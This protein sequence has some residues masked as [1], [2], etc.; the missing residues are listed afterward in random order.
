MVT[1]SLFSY[2][3]SNECTEEYNRPTKLDSIIHLIAS[4]WQ[5]L[6][7]V[8]KWSGVKHSV[9]YAC[10]ACDTDSEK[11]AVSFLLR[12]LNVGDPLGSRNAAISILRFLDSSLNNYL[13]TL[14]SPIASTSLMRISLSRLYSMTTRKTLLVI[15]VARVTKTS[16]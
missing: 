2:L 9:E 6:T 15:A 3:S 1:V 5:H 13:S 16:V 4:I 7:G 10:G 8:R 14:G 12:N 11:S